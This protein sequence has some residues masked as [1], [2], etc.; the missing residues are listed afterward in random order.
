MQLVATIGES[1]FTLDVNLGVVRIGDK[2]LTV[3][4]R[5]RGGCTV[6]DVHVLRDVAINVEGDETVAYVDGIRFVV[7]IESASVQR[8]RRILKIGATS[9]PGMEFAIAAPM[10]GLVRK[11][12]AAP[13][14]EVHVGEVLLMLEAM[15]MENEIRSPRNGI[16]RSVVVQPGDTV[17]KGRAL[18]RLE[19]V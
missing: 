12:I 9:G 7:A 15:K 3:S 11:V 1:S 19:S 2:E 8:A 14:M 5:E 17:D 18:I 6:A 16:V 10:P 13:G 4:R